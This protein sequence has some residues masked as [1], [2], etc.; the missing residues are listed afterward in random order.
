MSEAMEKRDDPD[1]MAE[2]KKE[3]KEVDAWNYHDRKVYD[4]TYEKKRM[5]EALQD[6]KKREALA[7]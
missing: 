4:Q 1:Y 6:P 3:V 5:A 2:P 7:A